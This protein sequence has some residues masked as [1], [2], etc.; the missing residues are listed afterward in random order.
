[1][2]AFN[3]TQL[4]FNKTTKLLDVKI[5]KLFDAGGSMESR[6]QYAH[7][8]KKKEKTKQVICHKSNG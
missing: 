2:Q 7:A 4:N 1:M 6:S 3:V 8:E 5:G